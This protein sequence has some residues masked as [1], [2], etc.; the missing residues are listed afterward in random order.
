[1]VHTN[2]LFQP[3]LKVIIM[4][5]TIFLKT[6]DINTDTIKTNLFKIDS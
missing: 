2:L 5:F 4:S 6:I 3:F 1:M